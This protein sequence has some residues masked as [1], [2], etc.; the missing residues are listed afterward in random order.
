MEEEI[1]EE[2]LSEEKLNELIE[3]SFNDDYLDKNKDTL[4]QISDE[5]N[6]KYLQEVANHNIY[7]VENNRNKITKSL[8]FNKDNRYIN[9][10][11]TKYF[12]IS[13]KA[14]ILASIIVKGKNKNNRYI[15]RDILNYYQTLDDAT[16]SNPNL[17]I[18]KC[19]QYIKVIRDRDILHD[20]KP[21][22]FFTDSLVQTFI[23][24]NKEI[25]LNDA[26]SLEEFFKNIDRAQIILQM[27]DAD[28]KY[29]NE[30]KV[31]R[32]SE[33]YQAIDRAIVLTQIYDSVCKEIK[34]VYNYKPFNE[35]ALKSTSLLE[36]FENNN[37]Y[38]FS[39]INEVRNYLSFDKAY[40][41]STY[42]NYNLS[43]LK[44]DTNVFGIYGMDNNLKYKKFD[45]VSINELLDELLAPTFQKNYVYPK[46]PKNIQN[47]VISSN[48]ILNH[49][50]STMGISVTNQDF[51][52]N[53]EPQSG[54]NKQEYLLL[55]SLYINDTSLYNLALDFKK[56]HPARVD[57]RLID[58][59][60]A[61]LTKALNDPKQILSLTTL[62]TKGYELKPNTIILKKNYDTLV[63][64]TKDSYSSLRKFFNFITNTK[65]K[66]EKYV[67]IQNEEINNFYKN[68]TIDNI[69]KEFKKDFKGALT[70]FR[71]N[72]FHEKIQVKDLS[73]LELEKFANLI[74]EGSIDLKNDPI[75]NK[76]S[77]M[78]LDNSKKIV[79]FKEN[80]F[81]GYALVDKDPFFT[82]KEALSKVVK[83]IST[84][85]N[86]ATCFLQ[87]I[88]TLPEVEHDNYIGR[89]CG[90]Y[91][92]ILDDNLTDEEKQI[93]TLE[94]AQAVYE[95]DYNH[96]DTLIKP[97]QDSL[98]RSFISHY[99]QIDMNTKNGVNHYFK[100]ILSGNIISQMKDVS[101]D[102]FINLRHEFP[103]QY[104]Y[105]T[106]ALGVV[107]TLNFYNSNSITANSDY[108]PVY[109]SIIKVPETLKN[110][111]ASEENE[112]EPTQNI[113]H[114]R[115]LEAIAK[116]FYD[117]EERQDNVID[118]NL[119]ISAYGVKGIDNSCKY[120]DLTKLSIEDYISE[121]ENFNPYFPN[122]DKL[123]NAQ[124]ALFSSQK[125]IELFT[126]SMNFYG[127]YHELNKGFVYSE[128]NVLG[129]DLEYPKMDNIFEAGKNTQVFFK[130]IY[131]DGVS[132]DSI[133]KSYVNNH[134]EKVYDIDML[135]TVVLT[136]ALNDPS[137]VITLIH[138]H[139]DKPNELKEY[140]ILNSKT[141]EKFKAK[142]NSYH[143]TPIVKVLRRNFDYLD[144]RT[145][146]STS[147]SSDYRLTLMQ[148]S[149]IADVDDLDLDA[150]KDDFIKN[151]SELLENTKVTDEV[152]LLFDLETNRFNKEVSDA[153]LEE[154]NK[155]A[156]TFNDINNFFKEAQKSGIEP[157]IS[158]DTKELLNEGFIY[159]NK[160]ARLEKIDANYSF[161]EEL[162]QSLAQDRIK[163]LKEL[164]D[165]EKIESDIERIKAISIAEEKL[166]NIDSF[167]KGD[168]LNTSLD[169][170]KI[171]FEKDSKHIENSKITKEKSDNVI[172]SDNI[173]KK[174]PDKKANNIIDIIKQ[175]QKYQNKR[176]RMVK[177]NIISR[178]E[179]KAVDIKNKDSKL[180]NESTNT[181]NTNSIKSNSKVETNTINTSNSKKILTKEE[182]LKEKER[183]ERTVEETNH[184]ISHDKDNEK[185]DKSNDY[186]INT[187]INNKK[188]DY[189]YI[190][191]VE[192][193]DFGHPKFYT[194][195]M[196]EYP[197]CRHLLSH[198]D[199]YPHYLKALNESITDEDN[200]IKTL[201]NLE[202]LYIKYLKDNNLKVDTNVLKE[203]RK[204]IDIQWSKMPINNSN[205][206]NLTINELKGA[207]KLSDIK[208]VDEL[209]LAKQEQYYFGHP[210]YYTKDKSHN[211]NDT[212]N[213][214]FNDPTEFPHY[215][216]ELKKNSTKEFNAYKLVLDYYSNLN[217]EIDNLES[218]ENKEIKK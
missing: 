32:S 11:I 111:N 70:L 174:E 97:I 109:K 49:L 153:K 1:I 121:Y 195:A 119:D 51:L 83:E 55:K 10:V 179:S 68:K 165:A 61:Y 31:N 35:G 107:N 27:K 79:N 177:S 71:E 3:N 133:I 132:L 194:K 92:T 207:T 213:F 205:K 22:Y 48:E 23:N 105:L 82:N 44:L 15:S 200:P 73:E 14:K 202:S 164:E 53:I 137:K 145:N 104:F 208:L 77:K 106:N 142:L 189:E 76:V 214:L 59:A 40:Y 155:N 149:K 114:E 159:E 86:K 158:D 176:K 123:T 25:K 136:K 116:V 45:D 47:A 20:A 186:T 113:Q 26:E 46:D 215:V 181:I 175:S 72:L 154:L 103:K 95:R 184:I 156:K 168:A 180:K 201:N 204:A 141:N 212:V 67:D 198:I 192:Q 94:Y 30:L 131:V 108:I 115:N 74:K 101:K 173:T 178:I 172:K 143:I 170:L 190:C 56:L 166:Q 160:Y 138:L 124:L 63:E 17:A 151:N 144:E 9:D 218:K 196:A 126:S 8:Y 206:T 64:R 125:M 129:K 130:S 147:K 21:L 162:N 152:E 43:Y 75:F 90:D 81:K 118:L 34:A 171:N 69:Q 66:E 188:S 91:Y 39:N 127:I 12:D 50:A 29:F 88:R 191:G 62:Q 4:N 54:L 6:N 117:A 16:L 209:A 157:I 42:N 110:M 140:E 167:S 28:S 80:D 85:Y 199:E 128:T 87:Y 65:T 161:I 134:S 84:T 187:N 57:A 150:I 93:K 120:Q 24:S 193:Y 89:D 60:A 197:P 36:S 52:V 182:K 18:K 5:L 102:Y 139:V 19:L 163:A 37:Q 146:D 33:Y 2:N 203:Y 216:N 41:D 100:A 211:I 135:R 112:K 217:N 7:K 148:N 13:A 38:S 98:I 122:L 210:N 58:I 96:N 169:N 183:V 99:Q 185:L 78:A